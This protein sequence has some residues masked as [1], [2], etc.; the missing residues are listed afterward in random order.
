MPALTRRRSKN[1]DHHEVWDVYFRDVHV[2]SVGE[3]AGVPVH[4]HQ[5][6]WSAG[7]YPGCEPGEHRSGTA[8]D[9]A[10]ARREFEVAWHELSA[11]KTEADYRAWRDDRDMKADIRARRARGEKLDSEIPSSMMRCFCGVS[12]DSHKPA[13]SFDHRAHIYAAQVEGRTW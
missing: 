2:G 11:T 6:K 9:F 1:H 7:F 10:A 4:V 13:E 3:R 12:F 8:T 5:W